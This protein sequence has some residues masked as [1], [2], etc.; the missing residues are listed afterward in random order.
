ME[1]GLREALRKE[2]LVRLCGVPGAAWPWVVSDLVDHERHRVVLV[3][4]PEAGAVERLA[5]GLRV[6]VHGA[7]VAVFAAWD[8]Q[9]YDRVGPGGAVVGER[10]SVMEKL[11]EAQ[12]EA[13][14][15]GPTL[16]VVTS[17]AAL[18]VRE[19][20][21][22]R[23][24]VLVEDG[25]VVNMAELARRMVELGYVREEVVQEAGRFAMRGGI[26][27]V[28]PSGVAEPVRIDLFGDE[29]ESIR[30]FDPLSQKS[31]ARLD[32][33]ALGPAQAVVLDEAKIA[34]FRENYRDLFGGG[35][36]DEVYAAVSA[37]SM[38]PE[39]GQLLPLFYDDA[40]PGLLDVL[41]DDT[42]VVLPDT[43]TAQAEGWDELVQG[44]YAA[45]RE[46]GGVEAIPPEMLY[47]PAAALTGGVGRFPTVE[48]AAFDD[49]QGLNPGVRAHALAQANRHGAAVA[50]AKEIKERGSE[51]RGTRWSV[52]LTAGTAPGLAQFLRAL[53]GEGVPAPKLLERFEIVPGQVVAAVSGISEGWVD[54]RAKVLVLTEGDV[55]GLKTG[56]AVARKRKKSAEEMIAHFSEL[57]EGD[58]VVHE[59]HGIG[60]FGGLVTLE[61]Q[62][63]EI[64]NQ[65]S[66]GADDRVRQ[67]FL[68]LFYADEDRLFVPVENLDVLS[69]YKG[70]D[71]GNVVLDKLGTGG[72]Q[73]RKDKV[74]EDLMAMAGELLATAS[75][76][77]TVQRAPVER[78][79][80]LYDEFCAGFAFPLTE[81]QERVMDEVEDD[82][83]GGSPMDRLVVGDVGFGKTEVALRSAFLMAAS[84][85][86]VAV[87]C[88]TTLLAR[89]HYEV[90]KERFNGF[91]MQV[92]RLSRL[93]GAAEARQVKEGLAR[94]TIDI[95]VG[96]H[97]L[98]GSQGS[99]VAGSQGIRFKNLGL[100]VIDEEQRFGVAHKEKLKQ[101]RAE[102]DILTLTATP[103]PRTLQMAVGGVRQLSLIT[104]PPVDRQAV[105]TFVLHWD[106]VTLKGAMT[107]ELVRGGQV[108]VVAPHV[109]DLPKLSDELRA[110]VPDARLGVAHGQMAE[111]E[112]ERVMVAFYEG[113]ID[114][115]LATTI[116]ESGLDVP[117]AN[118]LI[119]YRADRFG[120]AQLYQLR[121]RVGRSTAKAFAYFLLPDGGLGHEAAKRLQILQ[122]LEGLGAGFTLASYDMDLRGF[123]NILGKQQSGN[124]KDIG[125]ELYAKML[126]EAVAERQKKGSR[127]SGVAGSQGEEALRASS[128]S[129]KL[130]VTYLIPEGYMPDV[131]VRLQV[132]RRL[133]N[134]VDAEGLA[135]FKA[136]LV[137]RFGALPREV[138]ALLAVVDLRNRAAALNVAKVEVGEKGVVVGFEGQRFGDA[139]GLMR[140]IQEM[141]GVV[142]V[143]A[144]QSLVWHRRLGA[145]V[146]RGV[147]VILS[148]L[149]SLAQA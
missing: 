37:G 134:V 124:I 42:M 127:G 79:I 133:A 44:A 25:G 101:L 12:A 14:E 131:A 114:V 29:V 75:A 26:V 142:T 16:V 91:P 100:V 113:E 99:G 95:V 77:E 121:G 117:R 73:V 138:E 145:D 85:R 32:R 104:T 28:W 2:G 54:A 63:S 41:P 70:A 9:P 140:F 67:D 20:A 56:G 120:L 129:L 115:L 78:G 86:Q 52:M 122:R 96:T 47:V 27:D 34:R 36:G 59:E 89:Q 108:Y 139:A 105:Q 147:G 45:R 30:T 55:F 83:R 60:R 10:L 90:F 123:G 109:E 141:S 136:E 71:A 80:G 148:E 107:R 82:L 53:E 106:N 88:P 21:S 48:I 66:E 128:V 92:G 49:G 74:R 50:A 68:K 98:L 43:Y 76:R 15:P 40:L 3:V 69:R 7:E 46:A 51:E 110:L 102:V 94:G 6:L 4:A 93:V 119:V 137:D 18:G 146:L 64:R 132:Y 118:T 144:D 5:D 13:E 19:A 58:F 65:K 35:A 17:V 22:E 23:P 24:G 33:M 112:L 149:E 130:G 57:R 116:I 62:K 61:I 87:V 97:A 81:D 39:A 1:R 103:I 31:L 8:V 126:R 125:F 135:E 11:K 143:R 38:P 111:A 84:G 72:W